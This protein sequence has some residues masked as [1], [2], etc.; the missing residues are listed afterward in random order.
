MDNGIFR[1]KSIE[2]ISSP[3]QLGD[4]IR[5]SNPSIWII[6][7]AIIVLLI[8][9]CVWGIFGTIETSVSAP[10]ASDGE[11][12]ILYLDEEEIKTVNVG[13]EAVIED[14]GYKIISISQN[15]VQIGR[16]FDPYVLHVGEFSEGQWVYQAA[17][18]ADIP[19]GIYESSIVTEKISPMSFVIN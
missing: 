9:A 6:L 13:M 2:R 8:G 18:S 3:E 16:G 11:S 4:Y 10:V 1:K 7:G 5:V 19:D 17:L 12:V 15:P 14:K